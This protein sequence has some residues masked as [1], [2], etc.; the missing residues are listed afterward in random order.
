VTPGS[1]SAH[2]DSPSGPSLRVLIVDDNDKNRKLARDVLRAAGLR[3]LEAATG[4]EAIALAA[5][6]M[7]DVILLDLRL[8]DMDGMDVVRALGRDRR[9]AG[10]PVVALSASVYTGDAGGLRATGFAGY[11][12]KPIDVRE[13][14]EQVRRYSG[15]S[16][17]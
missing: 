11:L 5:E 2:D 15:R 7:P 12:E 3:T 6:G 9:T 14:P 13:F 8:P 4:G 1:P 10:I 16:G 17:A